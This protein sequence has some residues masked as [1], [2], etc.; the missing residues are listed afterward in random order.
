MLESDDP[1]KYELLIKGRLLIKLDK[2]IV[3]RTI[4]SFQLDLFA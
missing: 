2:P 3:N 1:N 4:K